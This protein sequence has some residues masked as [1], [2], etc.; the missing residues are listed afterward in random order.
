M[1]SAHRVLLRKVCL[2]PQP[3]ED[4]YL[5]VPANLP[6]FHYAEMLIDSVAA[7]SVDLQDFF[8]VAFAVPNSNLFDKVFCLLYMN[9]LSFRQNEATSRWAL[10]AKNRGF[11]L[12]EKEK[13]AFS[14]V[15]WTGGSHGACAVAIATALTAACGHFALRENAVDSYLCLPGKPKPTWEDLQRVTGD[16]LLKPQKTLILLQA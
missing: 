3:A 12:D 8:L 4:V 1:Q 7:L 10:A 2:L 13:P 5:T 6:H 9:H 16:T 15:M 14:D 11:L